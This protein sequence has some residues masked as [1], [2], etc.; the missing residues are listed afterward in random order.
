VNIENPRN[1]FQSSPSIKVIVSRWIS[2]VYNRFEYERYKYILTC[3]DVYSRYVQGIALKS[4]KK[5]ELVPAVRDMFENKMDKV[6]VHLNIDRPGI[7]EK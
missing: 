1:I 2:M 7:M 4:N 3:I 5:D 6:P